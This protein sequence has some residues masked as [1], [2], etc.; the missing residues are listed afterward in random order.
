VNH[1]QDLLR[2]DERLTQLL[3][4]R[5]LQ[6][7]DNDES[8]ELHS[9]MD[10]DADL[11]I[12]FDPGGFEEAAAL[13]AIALLGGA[14]TMPQ[15]M[16]S[17]LNA[18][19]S[20]FT[21]GEEHSTRLPADR[22]SAMPQSS[23]DATAN[24]GAMRLSMWSGWLAAAACLALALL[25]WLPRATTTTPADPAAQR[26]QMLTSGVGDLRQWSWSAGN[27]PANPG[28]SGDI[29]WSDSQQRGYMRFRGL[30]RNDPTREQY[31]LWIFDKQRKAD[32]PVV[33]GVFDVSADGEVII[34][35][36]PKLHVFEA[37]MFAVTVEK[38]GGVARSER[39]RI[40]VLAQPPA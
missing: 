28:I 39:E 5:A 33:G 1:P 32:Y 22:A 14:E 16:R 23:V 30:A 40:P 4:D 35:I 21:I 27:D 8:A 34:P 37:N 7:L 18:A 6:G 20:A 38:P 29:V 26:S 9:M 11:R 12:A 17:R 2:D 15:T 19:G 25:A 24:F 10:D 13:A 31:Q 3:L 36:D